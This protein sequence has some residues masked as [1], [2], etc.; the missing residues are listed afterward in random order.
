[1][2]L[3]NLLALHSG[4]YRI[5]RDRSQFFLIKRKYCTRQPE[6]VSIGEIVKEIKSAER[7][8]YVPIKYYNDNIPL[9]SLHHLRW[10][11]QKDILGQDIFL[12]GPPGPRKRNLV[13]QYLELTNREHEYVALSRDTTESDLKQR[14]EIVHGTAKYFDQSAVIAAKEGRVLVLE[15]IE[16]AERN[17]LPVLNNL[18]E[19]R[20]MHLE[21]GRLLI[22]AT[23]YDK[24]LKV[25]VVWYRNRKTLL[26]IPQRLVK[27]TFLRIE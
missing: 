16:K 15:G 25:C 5:L 8:E 17:V 9:S 24:L 3:K 22:P 11:M 18:L 12:L 20:E 26:S 6:S 14:R 23:R 10:M 27:M 19:N 13:M 4:I 2:H 7:P 1:M 21:D